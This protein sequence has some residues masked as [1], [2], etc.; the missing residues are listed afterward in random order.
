MNINYYKTYY[1]AKLR[2]RYRKTYKPVQ[3]LYKSVGIL[4]PSIGTTNLGDLIIMDAVVKVLDEVFP[5]DQKIKFPT[6]LYT[7][8]DTRSKLEMQ[9]YVFVG[10]TNLLASNLDT[11]HQWKIHPGMKNRQEL[12]LILLGTGWWQYQHQPNAYTSALLG[13]VLSKKYLHSVRDAYTAEKLKGVGISNVVNTACP[14][15][16]ELNENHCSKIPVSK[17]KNVITTLTSYKRDIEKDSWLLNTLAA[18]YEDVHIWVQGLEDVDYMEELDIDKSR[19]K[20]IPPTLTHFNKALMQEDVEYVGTRLHAG[21]R[22]LQL[23]KRCVIVAV[24]NRA[25]EI[26][27]DTNLNVIARE[28]VNSVVEFI[29]HDYTTRINLPLQNIQNWKAQFQIN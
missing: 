20:L 8:F 1:K 25:L 17:A 27:R 4:D 11:R 2:D 12:N 18:K 15:M 6:Q 19:F 28:N 3:S 24:D 13:S 7:D 16:W 26:S 5:T 10:G 29:D 14:T 9:D 23:K 22:A 21:I